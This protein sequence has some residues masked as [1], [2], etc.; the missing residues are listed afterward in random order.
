MWMKLDKNFKLR[1]EPFF[2][3]QKINWYNDSYFKRWW[4]WLVVD[5][6]CNSK[7]QC[8]KPSLVL[9]DTLKFFATSWV[10]SNHFMY[11]NEF[12]KTNSKGLINVFLIV[13]Q[14]IQQ[15]IVHYLNFIYWWKNLQN[16]YE[17]VKHPFLCCLKTL[18]LML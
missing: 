6:F 15:V 3:Q 16:S 10:F 11:F 7:F 12:Q 5:I 8:E 13:V 9:W 18:I 4:I 2:S 14:N 1:D 17:Y